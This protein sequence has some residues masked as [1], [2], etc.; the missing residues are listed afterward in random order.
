MQKFAKIQQKNN[1]WHFCKIQ[2]F[3]LSRIILMLIKMTGLGSFETYN[4]WGS[5]LGN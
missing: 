1:R 4:S 3:I 5:I 2:N